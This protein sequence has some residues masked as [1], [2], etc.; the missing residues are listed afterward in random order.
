MSAIALSVILGLLLSGLARAPWLCPGLTFAMKKLL[1][2]G[3][4]LL[5]LKLA[6]GDVLKVGALGIPVVVA[7]VS[8]GIGASLL[9]ARALKVSRTLGLLAAAS[10]GICGITATLAVAPVLQADDQEVA[11]TVANVTLFGLVGMLLYPFVAHALFA[12]HPGAAGAFLGTAIHDTSQ[13]M[14]AALS[15]QE[16]FGQPGAAQ[17]ATVTKLTRNALLVAVVP[18]LG[19]LHR[20]MSAKEC[21]RAAP[22][23]ELFPLFVLGFL[24]AALV[25]SVGEAGLA[26]QGLAF[27]SMTPDV[28]RG[29]IHQ[30]GEQTSG[31]LLATALAAVGLSTRLSVF[32]VLGVAPFLLG[33]AAAVA[34]S[35]SS[36]GL[37]ALVGPLLDPTR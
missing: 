12:A 8:I 7:V 29:L 37:A 34:V 14:G 33:L 6:I 23:S 32:R 10:T 21:G 24:A 25:R 26:S 31:M 16:M 30:L 2:L 20:R 5:G 3:I 35:L 11:Y 36:L 17:I 19:L 28:W 13:V 4:I 9:L 1:R 22:L 27:G 18:M 15:Y